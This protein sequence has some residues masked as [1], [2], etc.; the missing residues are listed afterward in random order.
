MENYDLRYDEDRYSVAAAPVN[1]RVVFLRRTYGHL[2]G[3]ILAFIGLEAALVMSGAGDMLLD[4]LR[5]LPYGML[6]LMV[7]FIGAGYLAQY[8]A[9]SSTS[10][11][12]RY[13]GLGLYV[14]LQ[15]IIILPLITYIERTP[16]LQGK[17]LPL[18]AGI[19]TAAA[20][21]G[22]TFAV[23]ASGKDFSFLGPILWVASLVALGVIL[24]AI[25]FGAGGLI[26][27]VFSGAMIL[28]AAGYIVYDTSNVIHH[29]RSDQ[30]VA[31]A[32]A[33]FASVALMFYYVLRLLMQLQS[34][35]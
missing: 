9:Q 32:L 10:N 11:A 17:Y 21:A 26:G 18:Q 4:S 3:A 23:T 15:A 16:S 5:A 7:G 34:N 33:L 22:L 25:L 35:R 29:Y 27:V 2:L 8:M 6:L 31:A 1:E 28:L 30:Y 20:F 19:I 24:C 14:V 12:A 13:A